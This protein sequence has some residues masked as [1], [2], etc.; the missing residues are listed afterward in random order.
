V[1]SEQPTIAE[2]SHR[3]WPEIRPEDVRAVAA[4]VEKGLLSGTRL[5]SVAGLEKEW[6]RR[7]GVPHCVATNSGTAALHCAV[8]A[9]GLEPG[10]EVIVPALT[11]VASAFAVA[12]H[13]AVPV[14]ADVDPETFTLDPAR[15]EECIG[16][17]TRAVMAVH[18][19]GMPADMDGLGE[20]ARRHGLEVVEDAAQAHGADYRGR[21]V[22][23]LGDSAAFSLN[24]TKGLVGG[25]G[26]LFV[27]ADERRARAA[28]RL[29]VFGED[30]ERRLGPGGADYWSHGLGWN[31]RCA[32]M[33]AA[34]A[35]S[36]LRRLDE[37][38]ARTRASV[39]ILEKGL[40]GVPG[41][42]PPRVPG[43]RT[44]V[45]HKYRV[46]LEPEALGWTG[47]PELLRD[48]VLAELQR[49]GVAA[50][51]WQRVPLPAHPAF[52]RGT[53]RPWMPGEDEGDLRPWDAERFPVTCRVLATSFL[54]GSERY[55]L[56]AQEPELMHAYVEATARAIDRL[57]GAAG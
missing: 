6:A 49:E 48:R 8:V 3:S 18:V 13:G 40:E 11:F 7:C 19:H 12:Q 20:I 31:Y 4:V 52:R 53:L 55:P 39:E 46:R 16:S 30:V 28:R 56:C 29:C 45:W 5:P 33:A 34:L 14:F 24:A 43:D 50:S 54:L 38:I 44:C 25:E 32:P 26:G 35:R 21:P 47:P 2:G 57:S 51:L 1:A 41:V 23:S 22:G 42:V 9:A 17:R 15:V 10:D 37:V 27:T 36:Q